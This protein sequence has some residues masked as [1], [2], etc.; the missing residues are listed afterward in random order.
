MKHMVYTDSEGFKWVAIVPDN[1][2]EGQSPAAYPIAGPP[3]LSVLGLSVEDTLKLH[4]GL[5]E[6]GMYNAPALVGRRKELMQLLK[7]L[8]LK[9]SIFQIIGVFQQTY[10]GDR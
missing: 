5:V 1:I 4:N 9:L 7:S 3:D 2:K 6:K 10:Y 8:G